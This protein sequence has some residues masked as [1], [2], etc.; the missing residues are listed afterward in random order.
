[1]DIGTSGG[2]EQRQPFA[3]AA[4]PREQHCLG[5]SCGWILDIAADGGES[6]VMQLVSERV[7]QLTRGLIGIEVHEDPHGAGIGAVM[8]EGVCRRLDERIQ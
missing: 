6:D 3:E 4:E 5:R 2:S 7:V 8:D 1:M